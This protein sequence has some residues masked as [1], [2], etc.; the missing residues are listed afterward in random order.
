MAIYTPSAAELGDFPLVEAGTNIDAADVN[1]PF[2]A[3]ADGVVYATERGASR[4]DTL[5]DLT[6]L[7]AVTTPTDGLIRSVV[8]YGLYRFESSSILVAN[9]ATV[10]AATDATPGKW[11][12]AGLNLSGAANGIAAL[13]ASSQLLVPV[14]G[15]PTFS[16]AT[17]RV[18]SVALDNFKH[19]AG[20]AT[21]AKTAQFGNANVEANGDVVLVSGGLKFANAPGAATSIGV[22]I[23]LDDYLHNGATLSSIVLQVQGAAAHAGLPGT[24]LSAGIFRKAKFSSGLTSLRSAGDFATDA[25][26]STGAYQAS[27]T[28]SLSPDQNNVIDTTAY[29]YH[30]QLWDEFGA[31]ALIGATVHGIELTNNLIADMRFP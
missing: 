27:H 9:A 2:Q 3:I 11:H 22:Q 16:S 12:W 29:S 5:A 18:R 31:N 21:R 30:L 14:G 28:L 7:A 24:Q 17:S 6:A 4:L 20:L 19:T 10:I 1:I 23:C 15:F 13:N 25:Q 26:A 8:D